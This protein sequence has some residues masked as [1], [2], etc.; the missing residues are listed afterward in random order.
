MSTEKFLSCLV[1]EIS[2]DYGDTVHKSIQKIHA[3]IRSELRRRLDLVDDFLTGSYARRTMLKP[4]HGEKFDLDFFIVFHRSFGD[5]NLEALRL[6]TI[7]AL[8][9]IKTECPDLGITEIV[10]DQRRS[11]GVRFN[12]RFQIDVVPAVEIQKDVLYK[13]FDRRTYEAVESNPKLHG[14]LLSQ[15]NQRSESGSI[16]RLVPI[17]KLL[18]A[19]K[20]DAFPQ[21]KSFHTELLAIALL[22]GS[23]IEYFDWACG[24]L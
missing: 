6:L 10:E 4:K 20:R 24:I 21:M 19:W 8:Q 1:S 23:Q 2:L 11:V 5:R 15:A 17:A 18:K 13:I 14:K 22:G 7:Q 12:G 9:E 3:R 16:R